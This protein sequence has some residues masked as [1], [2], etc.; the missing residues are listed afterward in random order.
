MLLKI[1]WPVWCLNKIV[2]SR[3][4]PQDKPKPEGTCRKA[5]FPIRLLLVP[6]C[7]IFLPW[8]FPQCFVLKALEKQMFEMLTQWEVFF[9][10]KNA[11]MNLQAEFLKLISLTVWVFLA[12]VWVLLLRAYHKIPLAFL[13]HSLWK[14]WKLWIWYWK[15]NL[16]VVRTG[17]K[18]HSSP[19]VILSVAEFWNKSI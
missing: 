15:K 1:W 18:M 4:G 12:I 10:C 7:H 3:R 13:C 17:K 5:E 2:W 8:L 14:S 6:Q 16:L 11:S 9:D 19:L